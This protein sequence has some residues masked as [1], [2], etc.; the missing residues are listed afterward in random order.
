MKSSWQRNTQS[1]A[2]ECHTNDS[3]DYAATIEISRAG[4]AKLNQGKKE[5]TTDRQARDVFAGAEMIGLAENFTFFPITPKMGPAVS[6]CHPGSPGLLAGRY[7]TFEG[8]C[9]VSTGI[10]QYGCKC[11]YYF[12]K[13]TVIQKARR[14]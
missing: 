10:G 2:I 1:A 13:L 9:Q 3:F 6:P 11:A 4:R 14:N 5:D 12:L 8:S 7:E